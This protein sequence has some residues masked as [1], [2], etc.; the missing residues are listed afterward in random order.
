MFNIEPFNSGHV[1]CGED[2]L[3]A[4][5]AQ[6]FYIYPGLECT[7]KPY[8]SFKFLSWQENLGGNS[9]QM[10]SIVPPPSIVDYILDFF[11]VNPDKPQATL[12]ITKFAS[13]TANFILLS[14]SMSAYKHNGGFN[15]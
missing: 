1:E 2:K 6:P 9:S 13:F 11:Y 15:Q 12:N 10:I 14:L 7:A 8:Q 3:I 5:I 4:P